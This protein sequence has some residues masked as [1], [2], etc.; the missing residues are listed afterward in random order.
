MSE[1]E[2]VHQPTKCPWCGQY[3]YRTIVVPENVGYQVECYECYA[4]GP[5]GL[6]RRDAECLWHDQWEYKKF[7]ATR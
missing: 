5:L 4:R 7:N 3:R 1:E 6:E 2:F